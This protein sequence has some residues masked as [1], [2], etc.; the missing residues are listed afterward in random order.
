MAK[1]VQ[2]SCN[3]SGFVLECLKQGLRLD[4]RKLGESRRPTIRLSPDEYGYVE[5]EWGKTK[6]AVRI[7][8]EIVQPYE[9]RPFEGLFTINTEISS[10]AS[11]QFENG[12]NT[13]DEVL[14]SRLVEKAIRRSNALDLESLCIVA[15][16]KVWHVRA[17]VNF[18]NFDGGVIDAS[19]V[20]VMTA[21]QHFRK[22]DVSIDGEDVIIHSLDERQPVP[23]SILHVPIC[24]TFLFFNPGNV[25]VNIKGDVNEEIAVV[26]TTNEEELLSQGF[27]VITVNKNR[28]LLQLSKNGGLPMD[29]MILLRLAHE[30]YGI[31]EK[32][33][34]EIKELLKKDEEDRYKRM[35]L[36]L[37]EVGADRENS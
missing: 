17:D 2:I 35:N 4:G 37:L 18:L 1:G 20:G 27:L 16:A 26:D 36:R 28:E 23:L 9:D 8:A 11:P 15:G 19:S 24:V 31:V 22:P 32:T 6:L 30:A 29:V 3:E 13:D 21:L 25:E 7:S 12:R 33:T 34:D 10:M 5:L 14:I